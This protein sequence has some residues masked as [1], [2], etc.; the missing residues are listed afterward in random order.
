MLEREWDPEG[1][2]ALWVRGF[3]TLAATA[4]LRSELKR[5]VA[6]DRL[7]PLSRAIGVPLAQT[8]SILAGRAPKSSTMEKLSEAL[9]LEFHIGP[10]RAQETLNNPPQD[11]DG[12][13]Q[14]AARDALGLKLHIGPARHTSAPDI[15]VFSGGQNTEIQP[16][17]PRVYSIGEG[18]SLY[19]LGNEVPTK[20]EF[21]I[22]ASVRAAHDA[23]G[24]PIPDDLREALLADA[25]ELDEHG[26][27]LRPVEVV[28]LAAAA[29]GGAEA[30]DETVTGRVWFRRDWL[31]A[32]AMDP[33]RCVVIGVRGESME[34]TLPNGCSILVDR[35]RVEPQDGR[36]YVL[37]TAD[38][39]VVKRLAQD[40]DWLA[41]PQRSS[42]LGRPVPGMTPPP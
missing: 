40:G 33:A 22:Q 24:D 39:V 4:Y 8:R 14:E 28:E 31:D 30:L 20:V 5:R 15:S 18:A 2:K 34:P 29:G 9:G 10:P 19:R 7:R 21:A 36:I 11:S 6:S 17:A 13:P 1:K 37:R 38:G 27:P 35:N 12:L 42:S 32:H 41:G 3:M 23:G 16:E 25:A 26:R